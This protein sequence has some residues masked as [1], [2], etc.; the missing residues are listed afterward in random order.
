MMYNV[1]GRVEYWNNELTVTANFFCRS[2]L[3]SAFVN[4]ITT[5][6]GETFWLALALELDPASS[7]MHSLPGQVSLKFAPNT[8]DWLC[9]DANINKAHVQQNI[10]LAKKCF[11]PP[12]TNSIPTKTNTCFVYFT[13]YTPRKWKLI[14]RQR[15]ADVTDSYPYRYS[16]AAK[17]L[18]FVFLFPDIDYHHHHRWISGSRPNGL[19]VRPTYPL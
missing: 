12:N 3:Y 4:V 15:C 1:T 13:V 5:C 14:D 18:R 9:S 7:S 17:W 2:R 11:V 19:Y 8:V 16:P 10:T 6:M